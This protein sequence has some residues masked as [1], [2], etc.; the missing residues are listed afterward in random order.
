MGSECL[1]YSFN[2]G[3]K[4]LNAPVYHHSSSLLWR[5]YTHMAMKSSILTA[6]S[7]IIPH[8]KADALRYTS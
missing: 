6:V 2:A 4:S 5:H 8:F 1:E 7:H 3:P